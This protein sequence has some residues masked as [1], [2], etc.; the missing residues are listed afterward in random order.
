MGDWG[1]SAGENIHLTG[2]TLEALGD[3]G[4]LILHAGKNITLDT[5]TLS[6]RKDMTE[7]RDTI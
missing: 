5:G 6:A 3:R 4:S 1:I 7:N 2:S